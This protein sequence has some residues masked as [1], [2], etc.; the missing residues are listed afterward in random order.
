MLKAL[1]GNR[2]TSGEYIVMN[3]GAVGVA[4]TG[5]Q[6][7]K[8][9]AGP[10]LRLSAR[11]QAATLIHQRSCAKRC[12]S[13]RYS[14]K[15]EHA[16]CPEAKCLSL[17]PK[18]SIC[19]APTSCNFP[20]YQHA[21]CCSKHT[22]QGVCLSLLGRQMLS[23]YNPVAEHFATHHRLKPSEFSI[24]LPVALCS[25]RQTLLMLLL[26]GCTG[27]RAGASLE[28]VHVQAVFRGAAGAC[29]RTLWAP[30]LPSLPGKTFPGSSS[31]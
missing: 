14:K 5:M 20:R 27:N 16:T 26:H 13:F 15:R 6:R 17:V 7:R 24:S 25:D 28:G 4:G 18:R 21:D 23:Q 3:Q 10:A 29:Q 12:C 31:S 22:L 19:V 30:L 2:S 9:G 1:A 8:N 11:S